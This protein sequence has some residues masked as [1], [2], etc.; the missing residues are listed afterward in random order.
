MTA[1]PEVAAQVARQPWENTMRSCSTS[2]ARLRRR[3]A[4]G[5]N[6]PPYVVFGDVSLRHMAAVIPQT[7]EEF[8]RISGVGQAKLQQY[9]ADFLQVIC[10]YAE[11]NGIPAVTYDAPAGERPAPGPSRTRPWA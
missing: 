1:G 9:G 3:L 2:C 8:G 11:A 5:R 7:L 10:A 6:V 4:D